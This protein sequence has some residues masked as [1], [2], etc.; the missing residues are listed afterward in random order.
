M[1]L[2]KYSVACAIVERCCT[3]V[4]VAQFLPSVQL[5]ISRQRTTLGLGDGSSPLQLAHIHCHANSSSTAVDST[6]LHA[7][8]ASAILRSLTRLVATAVTRAI[9]CLIM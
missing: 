1:E 6:R 4:A 5:A 7:Q 3:S 8:K 9:T 2:K